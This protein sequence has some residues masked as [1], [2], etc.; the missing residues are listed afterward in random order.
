MTCGARS[1]AQ[2]FALAPDPLEG[3]PDDPDPLGPL[4]PPSL[5]VGDP[6]E[7][8]AEGAE[9]DDAERESVR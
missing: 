9:S 8:D 7:E 3:D 2:A 1:T 4:D 6:G 5:F